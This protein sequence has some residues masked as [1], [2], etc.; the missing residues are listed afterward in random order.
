MFRIGKG[1]PSLVD[2]LRDKSKEITYVPTEIYCVWVV[3]NREK[4]V[5]FVGQIPRE[6]KEEDLD[7]PDWVYDMRDYGGGSKP[8]SIYGVRIG[9]IEEYF[10]QL[11]ASKVGKSSFKIAGLYVY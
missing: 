10:L 3:D 6:L 8:E 4:E 2:A 7:L 5:R 11:L 9:T 1:D